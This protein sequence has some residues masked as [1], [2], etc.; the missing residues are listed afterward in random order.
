MSVLENSLQEANSPME[1]IIV[2]CLG[3]DLPAKP[4]KEKTS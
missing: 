2:A 3:G 4:E 1:K